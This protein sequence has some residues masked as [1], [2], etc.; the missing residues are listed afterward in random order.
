MMRSSRRNSRSALVVLPG[1]IS[2]DGN[3]SRIS[4]LRAKKALEI[5]PEFGVIIVCGKHSLLRKET[6][7][8]EA[9]SLERWFVEKG[10]P[11]GRIIKETKSTDTVLNFLNIKDALETMGVSRATIVTS[12][13][14]SNRS[15]YIAS[16]I[17]PEIS[18]SS[19]AVGQKPRTSQKVKE[20]L[21]FAYTIA[22]LTGKISRK[23]H[24]RTLPHRSGM[25][26]DCARAL[27]KLF[28]YHTPFER[29]R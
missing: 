28:V 21:V 12:Q 26:G 7:Y 5:W 4:E 25:V 20:G 15:R 18:W 10:V 24:M 16:R 13:H 17:L 11:A 3:L 29:K 22:A 19:I 8:C 2:D 23:K 9:D 14:H 27:L 6:H 1:G